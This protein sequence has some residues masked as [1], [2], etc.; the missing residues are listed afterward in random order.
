MILSI[1]FH[2]P[3]ANG[4]LMTFNMPFLFQKTFRLLLWK[5]MG[6]RVKHVICMAG[7]ADI[8][9][10]CNGELIRSSSDSFTIPAAFKGMISNNN[11]DIAFP[12]IAIPISSQK[13]KIDHILFLTKQTHVCRTAQ[14]CIWHQS[15]HVLPSSE[16]NTLRFDIVSIT[17]K[18]FISS[19]LRQ[20]CLALGK[21]P[22]VAW[23]YCPVF[24]HQCFLISQTRFGSSQSDGFL[25]HNKA[26]LLRQTHLISKL[27]FSRA[28]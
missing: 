20:W 14:S 9:C 24:L 21:R 19:F 12:I 27:R 4:L 15:A 1:W 11:F 23:P 22:S 7:L 3:A 18:V 10:M 25:K 26:V 2:Q 28:C 8:F 16:C 13:Q 5:L 17:N 6:Q